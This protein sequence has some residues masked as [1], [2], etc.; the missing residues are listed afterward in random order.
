MSV[1]PGETPASNPVQGGLSLPEAELVEALKRGEAAAYEQLVRD[2]TGR[3]LAVA[4]RVLGNDED[5]RDALQEALLN[6]VRSIRGFQGECRLSTWLHRIVVNAC[7]MKLRA[8]KRRPEE[9]IDDLLPRFIADGPF[10]GVHAAHPPEWR[11]DAEALLARRQTREL[12]RGCVERL[13]E[14]YRIVIVLR[15]FEE[16]E[17]AEVARMLDCTEGAVKVRLHR[18]RQALRGLLDPHFREGAL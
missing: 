5:A 8:Q 1:T 18:A 14:S 7:L 9:P 3:L 16:L 6:A 11:L 2:H 13:P 10:E 15:D 4:R 17:T 12:I